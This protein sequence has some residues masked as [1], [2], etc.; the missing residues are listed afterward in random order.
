MISSFLAI[1]SINYDVK[2][3]N[4]KCQTLLT[5]H[6]C[7]SCVPRN[8]WWLIR[9][10]LNKRNLAWLSITQFIR[11]ETGTQSGDINPSKF[12]CEPSYGKYGKSKLNQE[13]DL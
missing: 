5:H 2:L 8:K 11:G 1:I 9:Q 13:V 12:V 3:T 10:I 7:K 4:S 6:C